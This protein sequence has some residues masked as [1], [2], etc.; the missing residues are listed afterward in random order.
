[1]QHAGR[2]PIAAEA[3]RERNPFVREGGRSCSFFRKPA[4]QVPD[5]AWQTRSGLVRAVH[6]TTNERPAQQR[7]GLEDLSLP[8]AIAPFLTD[9]AS[10]GHQPGC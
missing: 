4:A 1:M 3:S 10:T 6:C 7:T 2:H 5:R 9:V 8:V